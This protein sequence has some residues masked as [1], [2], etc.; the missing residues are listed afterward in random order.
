MSNQ[1]EEVQLEAS[2]KKE[3]KPL[4]KKVVATIAASTFLG[5]TLFSCSL[6]SLNAPIHVGG[7]TV[8]NFGAEFSE[9]PQNPE[10]S[11]T[12]T[13]ITSAEIGTC[14]SSGNTVPCDTE[15]NQEI[16]SADQAHCDTSTLY[17][18]VSGNPSFDFFGPSVSVSWKDGSCLAETPVRSSSI[19]GAWVEPT[20][21]TDPLR[22]CY[23]GEQANQKIVDCSQPH[24][25][26]IIYQQDADDPQDMRCTERAEAY[27]NASES[28]WASIL[29]VDS[30]EVEGDTTRRC[31]L[32]TRNGGTLETGLRNLKNTSIQISSS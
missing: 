23:A 9:P 21:V 29:R 28:S 22:A 10:T 32:T 19:R 4:L 16:I 15:H 20:V 24:T 25:G 3:K 5:I 12:N 8:N 14:L 17:S 27:T 7:T 2:A 13:T 31:V 18:Y 26:E 1:D 6:I 11:D 30:V